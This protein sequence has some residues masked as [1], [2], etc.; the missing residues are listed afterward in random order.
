M[1]V[2]SARSRPVPVT[3]I[4]ASSARRMESPRKGSPRNWRPDPLDGKAS[5]DQALATFTV[6][7]TDALGPGLVETM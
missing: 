2:I 3:T 4:V 1:S 5:P 7:A 6:R